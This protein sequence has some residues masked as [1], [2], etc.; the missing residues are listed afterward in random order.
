MRKNGRLTSW[1]LITILIGG[2]VCTSALCVLAY[3]SMRGQAFDGAADSVMRMASS[4]SSRFESEAR[5]IVRCAESIARSESLSSQWVLYEESVEAKKFYDYLS[6]V[7]RTTRYITSI[8]VLLDPEGWD[9]QRSEA[10]HAPFAVRSGDQ[11]IMT[12]LSDHKSDYIEIAPSGSQPYWTEAVDVPDDKLSPIVAFARPTKYGTIICNVSREWLE[13]AVRGEQ[14]PFGGGFAIVSNEGRDL[15]RE[16]PSNDD[17]ALQTV[18]EEVGYTGWNIEVSYPTGRVTEYASAAAAKLAGIGAAITAVT[19][20]FSL[21]ITKPAV[22]SIRALA[23][24]VRAANI[25]APELNFHPVGAMSAETSDLAR[26]VEEMCLGVSKRIAGEERNMRE[27][28]KRQ[29]AGKV[30]SAVMSHFLPEPALETGRFS[31]AARAEYRD[32]GAGIFYDIVRS[33]RGTIYLVLGETAGE[34]ASPAMAISTA[35]SFTRSLLKYCPEPNIGLGQLSELISRYWN[36]KKGSIS[37][38]LAEF[39]PSTGTCVI[40][41]AGCPSAVII[42]DNEPSAIDLPS[43]GSVARVGK[44]I[45]NIVLNM[46]RGDALVFCTPSAVGSVVDSERLSTHTALVLHSTSSSSE[47]VK[48]LE[49]NDTMAVMIVQYR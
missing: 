23:A 21:I 17:G 45:S 8:G 12:D 11:I 42:R 16:Q 39:Y 20:L 35:M 44:D 18:S 24:G 37:M 7:L 13:N 26:A 9:R 30:M 14:A 19:M 3:F 28:E 49:L 36:D 33:D 6:S 15:Y 10:S 2:A 5:P 46:G 1:I 4:L 34:G 41:S 29:D 43:A 48:S 32:G 47:A 31:I 22:R 40:A 38:M 27:A 25:D